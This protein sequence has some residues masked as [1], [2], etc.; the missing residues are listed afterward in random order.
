MAENIKMP[1]KFDYSSNAEF[2]VA[3]N[4]AIQ[5]GLTVNIDCSNMDYIDSAGIGLLVMAYKA[6]QSKNVKLRLTNLRPTPREILQLAN[7]QK[8][9]EIN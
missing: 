3:I 8:L 6:A 7:I 9:I 4:T 5:H 2:N 1:K